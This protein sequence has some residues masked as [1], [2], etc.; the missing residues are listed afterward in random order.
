MFAGKSYLTKFNLDSL[1]QEDRSPSEKKTATLK[2]K[3]Y[4]VGLF[5]QYL[6]SGQV[7]YPLTNRLEY[8]NVVGANKDAVI[9]DVMFN[10]CVRLGRCFAQVESGSGLP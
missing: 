2:H 3:L 6:L 7:N 1:Y 9:L 5:C 4:K 8:L 10:V